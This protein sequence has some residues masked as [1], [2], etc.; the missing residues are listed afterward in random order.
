MIERQQAHGAQRNWNSA[1]G[2][3]L[4]QAFG[5]RRFADTRRSHQRRIVLSVA[6]KDVDDARNLLI[7]AANR[8][9]TAG[10]RVSGQVTCEASKRAS[11]SFGAQQISDHPSAIG[12]DPARAGYSLQPPFDE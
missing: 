11:A 3:A 1:A 9:E 4:R 5:N 2:D 12:V 10:T 7:A 8:L 6:E